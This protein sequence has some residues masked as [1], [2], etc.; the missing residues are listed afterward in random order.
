[1]LSLDS[2]LVDIK[3]STLSQDPELL[4]VARG[5]RRSRSVLS[6]CFS[7]PEEQVK[8]RSNL[9]SDYPQRVSVSSN[10]KDWKIDFKD[11]NP[12]YF[13]HKHVLEN[14]LTKKVGG[15][16]DPEIVSP[17]YFYDRKNTDQVWKNRDDIK[18]DPEN[19]RPLNPNGRTG[20]QG[21]G[22]LG[23]WG[24]NFAVDNLVVFHDPD[25]GMFNLLVIQR[26]DNTW[27][28]PG[29]MV[30]AGETKAQALPR[31]LAEEVGISIGDTKAQLV[32]SGF[33]D[34]PRNTDNAWMETAAYMYVLD[35]K[36]AEQLRPCAGSDA[37]KWKWLPMSE[38]SISDLFASHPW[39]ANKAL[40]LLDKQMQAAA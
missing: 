15:W 30:D 27:A 3:I 40:C 25:S 13:V 6:P 35:A 36:Q 22:L 18:L 16:A 11:Y 1:M 38:D 32:F 24:P 8:A 21:R 19:G 12:K 33:C 29:G 9:V 14:D 34:D 20:L 37:K 10:L 7:A 28:F 39:I 31:E 5:D 4:E 23:H 17:Q 26:R 2:H